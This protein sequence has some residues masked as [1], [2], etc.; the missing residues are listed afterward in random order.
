MS[1]ATAGDGSSSPSNNAESA[2]D[3]SKG[4]YPTMLDRLRRRFM[5]K[6]SQIEEMIESSG[7]LDT[8]SNLLKDV[9]YADDSNAVPKSAPLA[10]A[11]SSGTHS[12]ET[13][14]FSDMNTAELYDNFEV[15]ED[16]LRDI[17]EISKFRVLERAL[18]HLDSINLTKDIGIAS[19]VKNEVSRLRGRLRDRRA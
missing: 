2:S 15:D 11:G 19:E 3:N 1:A 17:G 4:E 8:N 6:S 16:M 10:T 9:A 5:A 18:D 13:D 7:P 12:E 14:C